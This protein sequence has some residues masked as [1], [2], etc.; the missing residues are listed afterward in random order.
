M[1]KPCDI[2]YTSF[3]TTSMWGSSKNG[4]G[5]GHWIMAWIVVWVP[6]EISGNLRQLPY[7]PSLQFATFH[8]KMLSTILPHG[9]QLG[10]LC[11]HRLG[12]SWSSFPTA[13]VDGEKESPADRH[14]DVQI[15]FVLVSLGF[16][17]AS[18]TAAL[19]GAESRG[20]SR[21]AFASLNQARVSVELGGLTYTF[22]HTCRWPKVFGRFLFR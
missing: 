16:V 14:M 19:P 1:F 15:L 20:A 17:Y 6:S 13:G 7:G 3:R 2:L 18:W 5:M 4:C 9:D 22:D 12:R 21:T 10:P 8:S 11:L